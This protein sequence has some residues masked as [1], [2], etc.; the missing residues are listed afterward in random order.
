MSYLNLGSSI[1]PEMSEKNVL[2]SKMFLPTMMRKTANLIEM[3]A[4]LVLGNVSQI[5]GNC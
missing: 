3:N 4:K 5:F 2:R 1:A